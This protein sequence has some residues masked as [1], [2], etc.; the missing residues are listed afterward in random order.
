M[1][2]IKF[3]GQNIVLGKNQKEYADLP[4]YAQTNG[5][6][7]MCF[8]L[9]KE[10]VAGLLIEKQFPLT[11]LTFKRPVQPTKINTM[12][13]VLP[14]APE[15]AGEFSLKVCGFNDKEGTATFIFD[16]SN[17]ELIDIKRNKRI[18][19]SIISYGSPM[20]PISPEV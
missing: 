10:E 19:V 12:K 2:A 8:Q 14:M 3:K 1:K 7:T 15:K 16:L 18:W 4:A 20:Q 6:I 9:T 17:N 13:P 11:V 5:I